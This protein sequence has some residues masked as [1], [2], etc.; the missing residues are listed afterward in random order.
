MHINFFQEML[1]SQGI[2]I[3]S[4]QIVSEHNL[5]INPLDGG[6]KFLHYVQISCKNND[7]IVIKYFILHWSSVSCSPF[8]AW[9]SERESDLSETHGFLA[10]SLGI[11]YHLK[12]FLCWEVQFELNSDRHTEK[13]CAMCDL[14]LLYSDT[15]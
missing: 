12:G 9:M 5:V 8:Y 1:I 7:V 6:K 11:P 13:R 3:N 4:T 10:I 15:N 14:I 2:Y